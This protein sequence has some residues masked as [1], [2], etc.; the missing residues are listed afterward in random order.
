MNNKTQKII[1]ETIEWLYIKMNNGE[2]SVSDIKNFTEE[3]QEYIK[4]I[5][6]NSKTVKFIDLGLPSGNLWCDRNIGANSIESYGDYLTFDEACEYDNLPS[7][8]DFQEL[9]DNC[10]WEFIEINGVSGYKIIGKNNNSI[11]LPAAGCHIG[12]SFYY[13]GDDGRYWS[14]TLDDDDYNAYGLYF[15]IS[16]KDVDWSISRSIGHTVRLIK[17]K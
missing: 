10:K 12:S 14:F 8:K 15:S 4:T 3:Y 7:K 5:D 9:I 2:M 17:R 6:N 13:V 11:F 1:D 16:D